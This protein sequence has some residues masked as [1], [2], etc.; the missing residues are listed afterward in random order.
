MYDA[1]IPVMPAT[2]T[3]GGVPAGT[4]TPSGNVAGGVYPAAGTMAGAGGAAGAGMGAG[5][6][7]SGLASA[8]G[9]IAKGYAASKTQVAAQAP[10]PMQTVMFAAP[11][12]PMPYGLQNMRA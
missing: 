5:D 10:S 7:L 11:F 3:G 4:V 6:A 8:I 9:D 12:Q 2:A 1:F